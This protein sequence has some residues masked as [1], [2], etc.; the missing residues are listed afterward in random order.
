MPTFVT[1]LDV[2]LVVNRPQAA[3]WPCPWEASW[4]RWWS[5]EPGIRKLLQHPSRQLLLF[6]PAQQ[7]C[8]AVNHQSPRLSSAPL[9]RAFALQSP[10]GRGRGGARD[11][12]R[13]RSPCLT[14]LWHG[15]QNN[16]SLFYH[17]PFDDSQPWETCRCWGFSCWGSG[18]GADWMSA[19]DTQTP[20]GRLQDMGLL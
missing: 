6:I 11:Q 3:Q 18:Q 1:L 15:S 4:R 13:H 17:G 12:R 19:T 9:H 5:R 2:I 8:T 20:S 7:P 14:A 10:S 16:C